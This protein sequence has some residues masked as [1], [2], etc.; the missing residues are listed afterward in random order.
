VIL[1]AATTVLYPLAIQ[2]KRGGWWSILKPLALFTAVLDVAANYTEVAIVFGKPKP[3]KVTITRRL[4]AMVHDL[5][6]L[7]SRRQFA[8]MVLIFL[9]A[10]EPDGKH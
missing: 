10:C 9:D 5:D 6:E 3:G 8:G 7:P 2:F 4:K 1:T